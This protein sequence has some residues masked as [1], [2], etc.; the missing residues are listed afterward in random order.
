MVEV[1]NDAVRARTCILITPNRSLSWRANLQ[2]LLFFCGV[3]G[4]IGAVFFSLGFWL[5]LPFAGLELAALGA[6]LYLTSLKLSQRESIVI[7]AR[8]VV[9]HRG[10]Y[11]PELC[12]EFNRAHS[13]LEVHQ[14]ALK[15]IQSIRIRANHRQIPV[16]DLLGAA[17]KQQL[18]EGL[19]NL[20]P[21]VHLPT[22]KLQE[23]VL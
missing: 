22:K 4:L 11:K 15:E 6:V 18:V 12:G 8:S 10:R 1:R 14:A 13:R 17:E 2:V 19:Q 16:G 9:V 7:D 21:V 3:L 20:L 5:I 23:R